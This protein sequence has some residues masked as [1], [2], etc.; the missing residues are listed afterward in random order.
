MLFH[1]LYVMVYFGCS[2]LYEKLGSCVVVKLYCGFNVGGAS[3]IIGVFNL[4]THFKPY[5]KA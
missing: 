5:E 1:V 4:I 3:R 2:I